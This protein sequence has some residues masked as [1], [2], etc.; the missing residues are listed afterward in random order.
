VTGGRRNQWRDRAASA[1]R[2]RL[3]PLPGRLPATRPEP[4]A[5]RA[6]R[7]RIVTVTGISG[8]GLLAA[9]LSVRAGSRQFYLLTTG[10]AATWAGGA[11]ATGPLPWG[12]IQ[13]HGNVPHR[14]MVMPVLTGAGAFGLFYGAARLARHMP[15]LNQAIAAA[16]RYAEDGSAPL[17][18][19][20]ASANAVAEELF[21]RGA[22]W[23]LTEQAQAH[24]L[25]T[26]TLAY[27]VTTAVTRNPA[28]TIAGTATSVLFGLHRRA[29]GGVLAP[30]LT[31]L[32]WSLLM[33]HCLPPLFETPDHP[34]AR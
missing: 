27:T 28:L 23:S 21:F 34:Q 13:D 15:V 11:L 26:T 6:R 7:G 32:T 25:A 14:L 8:A 19:L 24:P 9:S 10:L 30:I 5:L 33:L 4:G 20:T 2:V 3:S 22:L 16:L 18:L 29:S 17:V 31:H 1:R 12:R